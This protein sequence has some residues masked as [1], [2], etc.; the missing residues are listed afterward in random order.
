MRSFISAVGDGEVADQETL[1]FEI[2]K[3]D[4]PDFRRESEMKKIKDWQAARPATCSH[5]YICERSNL[6]STV[7]PSG[8]G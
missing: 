7:V 2:R 6:T 5:S 4:S 3:F 1:V 8:T